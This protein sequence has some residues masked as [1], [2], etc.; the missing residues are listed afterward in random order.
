M[1]A[2]LVLAVQGAEPKRHACD[3]C[4]AP[5]G[6]PVYPLLN[7]SPRTCLDCAALP[8]KDRV[9]RYYRRLLRIA[10]KDQEEA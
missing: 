4:G 2:P 9:D 5:N 3:Y 7:D 10:G 1:S 6:S 8:T